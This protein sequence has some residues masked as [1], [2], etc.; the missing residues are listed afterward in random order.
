MLVKDAV[1]NNTGWPAKSNHGHSSWLAVSNEDER[2]HI[3]YMM[4][5]YTL[6]H[7]PFNR[8]LLNIGRD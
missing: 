3:F 1:E 6:S 5:D 2:F 8:F 4:I 7:Y